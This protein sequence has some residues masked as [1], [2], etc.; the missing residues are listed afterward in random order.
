MAQINKISG[1]QSAKYYHTVYGQ[2][3]Y[4]YRQN[5]WDIQGFRPKNCI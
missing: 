3:H 1:T 2:H 5:R 4:K